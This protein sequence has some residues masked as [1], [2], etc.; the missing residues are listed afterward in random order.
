VGNSLGGA[1]CMMAATAQPRRFTGLVVSD[2]PFPGS[3]LPWSFRTLRASLLGDLQI[4][5]L[6]RPVMAFGL[7]HRLYAD[8]RH[9]TEETI[10]DWWL[11]IRVPGTRRAALA[12]VRTPIRP[13]EGL[14]QR[15][16]VPTL[17]LW[18]KEDRLLP[19]EDGLRLAQKIRDARLVLLP[20]AGHL[21]Q[22]ETPGDFA[23]AVSEFL[24]G[25]QTRR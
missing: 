23:R 13:Y 8:A 24:A 22:E 14:L 4:E 20:G 21:P 11:P 7:R 12:A 1:V 25:L 2:S 10:D 17:V 18:G 9:V 3:Y 5:F 16:D 19:P 15:I 6:T